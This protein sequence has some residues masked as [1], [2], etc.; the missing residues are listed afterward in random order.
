MGSKDDLRSIGIVNVHNTLRLALAA[1]VI[2]R[3]KDVALSYRAADHERGGRSAHWRAWA[4]SH[5]TAPGGHWQDYGNKTLP[6]FG[7]ARLSHAE[8]KAKVL[9]DLLA[10]ATDTYGDLG[11]T[12]VPGLPGNLLPAAVAAW[13]KDEVAKARRA[14][15]ASA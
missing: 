3:G 7:D 14:A 13:V 11:W 10:W 1:G 12:A 9:A 15:K 5:K 6:L 8:L 2:D 4:V